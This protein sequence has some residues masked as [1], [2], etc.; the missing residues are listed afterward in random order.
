M[1]NWLTIAAASTALIITSISATLFG[2]DLVAR[3][4]GYLPDVSHPW[5]IGPQGRRRVSNKHLIL[6][7]PRFLQP[8]HY[9]V[10]PERPTIVAL[11]DSFTA[12]ATVEET[13]SY[14][15][16]LA[17]LL[18]E[19][20]SE[21]NI[22]NMGMGDSSPDQQLR[23]FKNY[24]LANVKPDAVIWA[25]YANDIGDNWRLPVYDIVE[26]TLHPM[27]GGMHWLGIRHSVHWSIPLPLSFKESSP[28]L[29]VLY[30]GM[31]IVGRPLIREADREAD[32]AKSIRKIDLSIAE[33][34]RLSRAH[35]FVIYY[36]NIAPQS[37]YVQNSGEQAKF[38]D[39]YNEYIADLLVSHYRIIGDLLVAESLVL[40]A[41]FGNGALPGCNGGQPEA[42]TELLASDDIFA[43]PERDGNLLGDR[44]FNEVGYSLLAASLAQC[45]Q[46]L[47]LRPVAGA[48]GR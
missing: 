47:G 28:L 3:I 40:D 25:F 4:T 39:D 12:G 48:P 9:S 21:M 15:S 36:V 46:G 10:R 1:K 42:D 7:D 23:L 37:L 38:K 33:M 19:Q 6:V 45:L 16:V 30:V 22:I 5:L 20:G 14:P 17:R 26:D 35:G 18:A 29:R 27:D 24:V 31:E 11:G 41:R 44:H 43:G 34:N 2:L 32:L 13:Q 8:D